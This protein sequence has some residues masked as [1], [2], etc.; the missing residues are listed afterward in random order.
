MQY[1][2]KFVG[3]INLN[4]QYIPQQLAAMSNSYRSNYLLHAALSVKL[5]YII[6]ACIL[7]AVAILFY[8]SDLPALKNVSKEETT[9]GKFYIQTGY[10][11]PL[12]CFLVVLYFGLNGYKIKK[13]LT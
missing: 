8:F 6:L 9:N 2:D 13:Q 5:P 7:I 3:F 1:P 4:K 10:I 12:I 11:I